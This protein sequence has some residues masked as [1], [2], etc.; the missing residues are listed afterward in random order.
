MPPATPSRLGSAWARTPVP[1][2][3]HV[4]APR[5]PRVRVPPRWIQRVGLAVLASVA[6]VTSLHSI[7]NSSAVR[8]RLRDKVEAALAQRLG[9]VELGS[10]TG[11]DWGLHL[12]FGPLRVSP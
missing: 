5:P 6:V 9:S 7:L 12:T 8:T 4:R 10:H 11:V 2:P 1:R 3:P